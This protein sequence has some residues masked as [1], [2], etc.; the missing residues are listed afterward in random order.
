[1]IVKNYVLSSIDEL[2]R[3]Y[4]ASRSQKK[5]VYYSKLALLELCGW[6]EE[7]MDDIVLRYCNKKLKLTASKDDIK[8]IVK[9]NAGFQY[10]SNFRPLLMRAIGIINLEKIEA[11]LEKRGKITRLS[12]L[13]G[14]LKSSRNDAA[15]T[16]LKGVTRTYNAPSK[17]KQDFLSIYAILKEIDNKVRKL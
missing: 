5:A 12:S 1:M 6:I 11:K 9:N 7:S 3:L 8:G 13:L 16:F 14:N 2:D 10:N 15:H 4:N 17:I